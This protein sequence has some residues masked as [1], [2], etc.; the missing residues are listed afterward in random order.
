M[1]FARLIKRPDMLIAASVGTMALGILVS[2][3]CGMLYHYA[4]EYPLDSGE[5]LNTWGLKGSAAGSLPTLFALGDLFYENL[6]RDCSQKK[7]RDEETP[8]V[9]DENQSFARRCWSSLFNCN[10]TTTTEAVG[11]TPKNNVTYGSVN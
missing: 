7:V 5:I 4:N 8:L 6:K 11:E 9:E 2:Y 10:K 3:S 1:F